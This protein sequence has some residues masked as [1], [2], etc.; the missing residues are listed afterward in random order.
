[1]QENTNNKTYWEDYVSYWENKV[2]EANLKDGAKDKTSTDDMMANQVG[3]LNLKASDIFLDYGCGSGR[4]YYYYC[5]ICKNGENYNGVDISRTALEHVLRIYGDMKESQLKETDG[6]TIPYEDETFDKICCYGVFDACDQ[7]HTLK[8]LLRVLKKEGLLFLT[9]K[10]DNYCDDD[11]EAYIAEVNAR[12]KKHPN[13]FTDVIDMIEQLKKKGG[14]EIVEQFF[15]E[16]RGDVQKNK[17]ITDAGD[18]K[19]YEWQLIIKKTNSASVS[20]DKFSDTY[21]KTFKRR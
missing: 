8:E 19:F 14:V 9:G 18:K 7:E 11:D 5:K 21:S 16:R 20:F 10:N 13:S 17:F 6:V 3:K 4:F 2:S 15:F 1:M 12:K